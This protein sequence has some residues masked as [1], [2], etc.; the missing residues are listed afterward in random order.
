MG[1]YLRCN[2]SN[3]DFSKISLLIPNTKYITRNKIN[4]FFL[5]YLNYK[6]INLIKI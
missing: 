3:S 2:N 1:K 5:L 6:K 4:I